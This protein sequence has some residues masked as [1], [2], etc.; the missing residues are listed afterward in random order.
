MG[1]V[2]GRLR[3]PAPLSPLASNMLE[4]CY[5]MNFLLLLADSEYLSRHVL[6]LAGYNACRASP[7]RRYEVFASRGER[8]EAAHRLDESLLANLAA[9]E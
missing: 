5:K 6:L 4:A 9:P 2:I 3:G 7:G 1:I 8:C